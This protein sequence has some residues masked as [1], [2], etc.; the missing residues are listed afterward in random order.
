[1]SLS[2]INRYCYLLSQLV[3]L[4]I[5]KQSSV[6]KWFYWTNSILRSIFILISFLN[7]LTPIWGTRITLTPGGTQISAPWNQRALIPEAQQSEAQCLAR[8]IAFAC[9]AHSTHI[10]LG[11]NLL[12]S[13]WHCYVPFSKCSI[14]TTS[15]ALEM[16]LFNFECSSSWHFRSFV[17]LREF[18]LTA[19]RDSWDGCSV[20]NRGKML[21]FRALC[22]SV[23]LMRWRTICRFRG[24]VGHS[25][26]R[27][28]YCR[29]KLLVHVCS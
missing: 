7:I 28:E 12:P 22:C 15:G 18:L 25:E 1:M 29:R 19:Y 9:K 8:S 10:V 5:W 17:S 3:E 6:A 11:W 21:H 26:V 27:R 13:I 20:W 14:T 2:S 4:G 16:H 24:S 23:T